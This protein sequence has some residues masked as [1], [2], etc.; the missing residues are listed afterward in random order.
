MITIKITIKNL[1]TDKAN[2]EIIKS[3]ANWYMGDIA[4]NLNQISVDA[5]LQDT[6]VSTQQISSLMILLLENTITNSV[7]KTV[8]E[9]MFETGQDPQKIVE[10][11][12]LAQMNNDD[13]IN[14]IVEEILEDNEKAIAD[15]QSGKETAIGFL[16]G[17]AMKATRG[18]IN[19]NN[20][21][22]VIIKKLNKD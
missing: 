4:K 13:E 7:A 18:R 9:K 12:G 5:E 17:Q 1:T 19:A 10:N 16:V 21:K 8:L 6:K 14:K 3:I 20:V 11:E 2:L 15:F 22:E